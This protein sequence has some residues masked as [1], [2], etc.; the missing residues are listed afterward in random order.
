MYNINSV[1][2]ILILEK[3]YAFTIEQNNAIHTFT[4]NHAKWDFLSEKNW[5]FVRRT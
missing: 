1:L 5:K 4:H 2:L 3:L